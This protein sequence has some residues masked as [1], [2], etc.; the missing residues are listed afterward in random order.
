LSGLGATFAAKLRRRP[1]DTTAAATFTVAISDAVEG[2]VT[3]SLSNTLT[4]GLVAEP[5]YY[6]VEMTTGGVV[7]RLVEG[8]AFVNFEVTK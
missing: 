4:A 6:D 3:W 1:T 5:H 8:T 2:E 7:R